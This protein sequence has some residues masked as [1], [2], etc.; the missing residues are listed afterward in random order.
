MRIRWVLLVEGAIRHQAVAVLWRDH[1][2]VPHARKGAG[3]ETPIPRQRTALDVDLQGPHQILAR[4]AA[5]AW[6]GRRLPH[7]VRAAG[8]ERQTVVSQLFR[9]Q[10]RGTKG[11]V[12]HDDQE[13]VHLHR[14]PEVI[15]PPE[16]A[17]SLSEKI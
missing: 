10:R 2:R 3:D 15:K 16:I 14:H 1:E 17:S 5:T 12:R 7:G 8:E 13:R 6:L 9:E 4:V 11:C